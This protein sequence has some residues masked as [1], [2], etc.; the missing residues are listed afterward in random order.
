[1][2]GGGHS[3]WSGRMPDYLRFYVDAC[4]G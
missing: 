2:H 4:R 1:V 3:G